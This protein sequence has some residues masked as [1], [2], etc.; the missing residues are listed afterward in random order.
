MAV[1]FVYKHSKHSSKHRFCR[2]VFRLDF[3]AFLIVFFVAVLGW[4]YPKHHQSANAA[5]KITI[6]TEV[7]TSQDILFTHQPRIFSRVAANFEPQAVLAEIRREVILDVVKTVIARYPSR[8]RSEDSEQLAQ[9]LV[10][11]GERVGIDPL[12]LAAVIRIESAF[13]NRAVSNVGARGL[14]QVMPATGEEV[15]SKIGI[16][17][18][19]PHQLHIPEINVRLGVNYL[20]WL[21]NRYRGSYKLALT[22]YNRGP[23]VLGIILRRD[24]QLGPQFTEYYRKIRQTYRAYIRY[25][26]EHQSVVLKTT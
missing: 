3:L 2:L 19:G 8:I 21:L 7:N 16:V 15:A 11:E 6:Q 24:G 13:C 1:K 18:E 22:A 20:D 5:N 10:A 12:F 17:W 26:K 23:T 9:L 14:M 25:I 4:I